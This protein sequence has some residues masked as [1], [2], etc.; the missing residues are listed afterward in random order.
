MATV[1]DQMRP[2]KDLSLLDGATEELIRD[3]RGSPTDL[4]KLVKSIDDR[5]R[6]VVPLSAKALARWN[7]D[8]PDSWDRVREWLTARGVRLVIV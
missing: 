6:A 5:G 7:K 3:L 2:L 8:D 1:R 4:A